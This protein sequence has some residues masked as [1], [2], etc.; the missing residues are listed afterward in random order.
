MMVAIH[1]QTL[2]YRLLNLMPS[3]QMR[4]TL[5]C[6]LA[7]FLRSQRPRPQHSQT[8]SAAAL[9]R[10]LNRD[11]WPPGKAFRAPRQSLKRLIANDCKSY[12]G[13]RPIVY[14][15]VDLTGLEQTGKYKELKGLVRRYNGK[16][17]VHVA[18]LYLTI[19]PFRCPWSFRIDR[20]KAQPSR[21]N[22]P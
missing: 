22:W 6:L 8:Q 1:A 21:P 7:L 11:G 12:R 14:A 9:S 15:V 2:I 4:A 13:R 20:A 19:G 18:L 5:Q 16:P 10:C 3:A 17:G